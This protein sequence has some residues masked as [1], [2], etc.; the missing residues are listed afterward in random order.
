[1]PAIVE[2]YDEMPSFIDFSAQTLNNLSHKYEQLPT[3]NLNSRVEVIEE[4]V[5]T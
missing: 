5:K 2:T 4:E 1:V 3:V